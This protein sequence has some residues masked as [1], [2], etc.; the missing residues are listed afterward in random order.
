MSLQDLLPPGTYEEIAGTR[1]AQPGTITCRCPHCGRELPYDVHNPFRP[2]CSEKCKLLDL[3]A[4]A[5][6]EL[7][8]EGNSV[9]EDED[10]EQASLVSDQIQGA[11]LEQ[12]R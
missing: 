6:D 4:W 1:S 5:N 12:N 3:D 11:A 7:V 8:I 2:F 9:L 10:A